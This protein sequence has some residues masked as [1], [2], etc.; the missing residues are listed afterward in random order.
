MAENF[1]I[2]LKSIA[3]AGILATSTLAVSG[4]ADDPSPVGS[5]LLPGSDLV[6]VDDTTIVVRQ[7]SG[8]KAVPFSF[9]TLRSTIALGKSEGFEAWAF[10]HF[11]G[12]PDSLNNA[13]LQSA[14][15]RLQKVY[16]VGDSLGTLSLSVH[17]ALSEWNRDSFVF[18]SLSTPGIF[19]PSG[20][21]PSIV[22]DN[23]S[24]H[25]SVDTTIVREWIKAVSDTSRRN[26]GIALEPKAGST[27]IRGFRSGSTDSVNERPVLTIRY[28]MSGSARVDTLVVTSVLD[29]FVAGMSDT[30]FLR[31]S[32]LVPARGGAAYRG[33]ISVD[34][35]PVPAHAAIHNATLD[36]TFDGASSRLAQ[37]QQRSLLALYG[38]VLNPI[39]TGDPLSS[40]STVYRFN[41]TEFVQAMVRGVG[42]SKIRL[43][44]HDEENSVSLFMMHGSAA[45]DPAKR[46]KITILYSRTR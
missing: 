22:E 18:D 25:F 5:F 36:L 44:V 40:D 6:S 8:E 24:I 10:L 41:V 15:V 29:K 4:C 28:I 11:F 23:E 7:T 16:Y 12:L 13:T 35:S 43:A 9:T 45:A 1:K 17:K 3:L 32:T 14:E 21:S 31:D 27:V 39:Q 26:F 20:S 38:G 33:V 2:L 30:T 34:V 42:D 19:D 46:P 37:G